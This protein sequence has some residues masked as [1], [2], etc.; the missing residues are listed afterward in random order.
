MLLRTCPMGYMWAARSL[1]ARL[2]IMYTKICMKG[3]AYCKYSTIRLCWR[4]SVCVR[5]YRRM[6]DTVCGFVC[7]CVCGVCLFVN[8]P[9]GQMNRVK[10]IFH[11]KHRR[12][13]SLTTCFTCFTVFQGC[14]VCQEVLQQRAYLS[15]HVL[16]WI[17]LQTQECAGGFGS[18]GRGRYS[19]ARVSFWAS[20]GFFFSFF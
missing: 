4:V 10:L 3:D 12:S 7:L 13:P 8:P 20:M 2:V 18:L 9:G 19:H 6:C 14:G 5:L 15:V 11:I 16:G 1:S 17:S